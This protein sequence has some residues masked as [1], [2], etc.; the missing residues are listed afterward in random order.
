MQHSS[1]ELAEITQMAAPDS[2]DEVLKLLAEQLPR[3]AELANVPQSGFRVGAAALGESGRVYLGANQEFKGLPLNFTIHAEQCAVVNALLHGE[4][5][6]EVLAVSSP[7]CGYCRQFLSELSCTEIKITIGTRAFT[8][9][10]LLPEAFSLENC[11]DNMLS[12]APQMQSAQQCSDPGEMA[13]LM[14][15]ASYSPYT[16]TLSGMAIVCSSGK[17]YGGC[18]L[19]SSAYNPSLTSFQTA[20]ISRALCRDESK[21]KAVYVCEKGPTSIEIMLPLVLPKA[22]PSTMIHIYRVVP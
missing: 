13:R 11:G 6:I 20:M 1:F 17:A 16:G 8:L 10:D 3:A 9:S 4:K 18:L 21:V 22:V 2:S 14:A 7:P 15:L 5:H 12:R 19:E